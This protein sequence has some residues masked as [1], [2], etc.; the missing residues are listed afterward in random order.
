MTSNSLEYVIM[1]PKLLMAFKTAGALCVVSTATVTSKR[2]ASPKPRKPAS[3]FEN[4]MPSDTPK[5]HGLIYLLCINQSN[6]S[7]NLF[8]HR[9]IHRSIHPHHSTSPWQCS[10]Y[11]NWIRIRAGYIQFPDK[12]WQ[13][14]CWKLSEHFKESV[15]QLWHLCNVELLWAP[16]HPWPMSAC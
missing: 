2:A 7:I 11:C 14:H 1:C 5:P 12:T 10:V 6:Q 13:N 15:V 4:R 16:G 3:I 8:I 9:W